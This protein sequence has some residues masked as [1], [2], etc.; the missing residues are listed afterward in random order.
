[1]PRILRCCFAERVCSAESAP[2]TWHAKSIIVLLVK[3]PLKLSLEEI[4]N[5]VGS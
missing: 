1:M 5:S 4:S 2:S 3:V